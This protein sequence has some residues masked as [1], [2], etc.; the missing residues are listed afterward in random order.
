MPKKSHCIVTPEF[1][2]PTGDGEIG[3]YCHHLMR[4]LRQLES[5][6]TIVFTGSFEKGDADHWLRHFRDQHGVEFYTIVLPENRIHWNSGFSFNLN[7]RAVAEFLEGR[8]FDAIHFQQWQGNG[9]I[10][11]QRR[12]NL[13][14]LPEAVVTITLHSSSEWLAEE[15]Q[16]L[17]RGSVENLLEGY[18]ERYAVEHADLVISPTMHLIDRAISSGWKLPE[19]RALL[20]CFIDVLPWA[21][22]PEG[23]PDELIYYGRLETSKGLEVFAGALRNLVSHSAQAGASKRKVTF[24]GKPGIVK[25]KRAALDF[26]AELEDELRIAFQITVESDLDYPACQDYLSDHPS[27]L[28][29]IAPLQ[30][31]HPF[32]VLECLQQGSRFIAS[33]IGGIPEMMADDSCL[34]EP[35]EPDLTA[36]LLEKLQQPGGAT[37]AAYSS[38]TLREQ[39]R[40][41]LEDTLPEIHRHK[42]T[43][44]I[45]VAARDGAAKRVTICV[46]HYNHGDYLGDLLDSLEKQTSNDFT[47]IAVDDGSTCEFSRA[48]FARHADRHRDKGWRFLT[49]PNGGIGHT[50]NDA[51][52]HAQ[53]DLLIFMDADNAA[54]PAM[55]KTFLD[56]IDRSG[57]DCLTSH[58]LAFPDEAKP[59]TDNACYG[60]MPVGPCL[61]AGMLINVFGDANCIIRKTAYDAVGGFTED[62]NTSYEDWELFA[63]LA[64]KGYRLDV[65]PEILFLYRHAAGGFSRATSL[66][67]NHLRAMRPYLEALPD[68]QRRAF[69]ALAGCESPIAPESQIA[70]E[71]QTTIERL[72]SRLHKFEARQVEL[73]SKLQEARSKLNVGNERHGSK[74]RGLRRIGRTLK[75][76][77]PHQVFGLAAVKEK[78][79]AGSPHSRTNKSLQVDSRPSTAPA[80]TFQPNQA[81]RTAMVV[82]RYAED[83]S[84]LNSVPGNIEI[85]VI[86]KGKPMAANDFQRSGVRVMKRTNLGREADS[87]LGFIEG[88]YHQGY[89]KIIFTQ[90]DPFTHNPD[91]LSLLSENAHWSNPQPLGCQWLTKKSLPPQ[92]LIDSE[93]ED[94]INGY[95]V[96]KELFSLFTLGTLRYKDRGILYVLDE[97]LRFHESPHGT[98]I[99]EHFFSTVGLADHAERA[100]RSD[101][102]VF[103]FSALFSVGT[104]LIARLPKD[105]VVRMRQL[106]QKN[107]IHAYI[108]ERLWLHLF[109]YPFVTTAKNAPSNEND[110][111]SISC[112]R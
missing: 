108:L 31:S 8:Q 5:E 28:V 39:W 26:L 9:F 21:V 60:H 38:A 75:K 41:L 32:T 111:S 51:A 29:V 76:F 81:G 3:K 30:D 92:H 57:C 2:G 112:L 47:V 100:A 24:L 71:R 4:L 6:V 95:K 61:E 88:D 13:G 74:P 82:A 94:W 33:R 48:A 12:R 87:Y 72:Q 59:S 93:T 50:R 90:G 68:W 84:W 73:K 16:N 27:A 78:S 58:F 17:R 89:D 7:S 42:A 102:G 19:S 46:P 10:P 77:F 85:F 56:A 52:R 22:I 43:P 36:K 20:P 64:L 44:A 67:A 79:E 101:M 104:D 96:R 35:T 86:N 54:R 80:T 18:C 1:L 103:T 70:M 97:Y 69:L 65:V 66:Y 11:M 91:F 49:K 62:R 110:G 109:D 34:F 15:S 53:T 63:R 83:L 14:T 105:S 37:A 25:N 23:I 45:S 55:V 98:N 99:A 107:P 40:Q 106:C